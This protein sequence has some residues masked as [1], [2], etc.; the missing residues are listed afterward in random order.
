MALSAVE[1]LIHDLLQLPDVKALVLA[2]TPPIFVTTVIMFST[3]FLTFMSQ[4]C[5]I[6][7][8]A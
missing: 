5:L 6:A 4:G 8:V 3:Y 7:Y 1:E 2:S